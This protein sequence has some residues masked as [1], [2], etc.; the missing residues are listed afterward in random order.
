MTLDALAAEPPVSGP[1]ID[2]VLDRQRVLTRLYG[3][4]QRLDPVDR[5]VMLSYLDGLEAADTADI[6]GISSGA[7]AMKVHRIKRLLAQA[8][9][10]GVSHDR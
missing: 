1:P 3:L 8:F 9:A 7:V 6:V 10:R 4:I 2:E 5:Q